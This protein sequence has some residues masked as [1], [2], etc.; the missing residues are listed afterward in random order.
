MQKLFG[1]NK[2]ARWRQSVNL[3]ANSVKIAKI[4]LAGAGMKQ[5][6]RVCRLRKLLPKRYPSLVTH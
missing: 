2:G 4:L 3:E 6:S 5:A 1:V